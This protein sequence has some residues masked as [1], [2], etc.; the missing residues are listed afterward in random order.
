MEPS[1]EGI[2][3]TPHNQ[4][5]TLF[6]Y[7]VFWDFFWFLFLAIESL[8][9]K[10]RIVY[11]LFNFFIEILNFYPQ[12]VIGDFSQNEQKRYIMEDMGTTTMLAFGKP[13]DFIF[14]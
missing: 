2:G 3:Q 1:T 14:G 11:S 6:C 13:H 9:Q 10:E 5:C 7:G 8:S 12:N 4:N